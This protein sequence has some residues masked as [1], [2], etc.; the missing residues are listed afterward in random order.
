MLLKAADYGTYDL[1][2]HR[3]HRTVVTNQCTVKELKYVSHGLLEL[4]IDL[5]EQT[6]ME[7]VFST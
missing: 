2:I 1:A 6:H 5:N 4:Y 7:I 3:H